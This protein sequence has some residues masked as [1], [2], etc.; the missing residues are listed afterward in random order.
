MKRSEAF[1]LFGNTIDNVSVNSN[2]SQPGLGENGFN[3][4]QELEMDSSYVD[5]HADTVQDTGSGVRPVQLHSHLFYEIL[6]CESADFQYLIGT[7]R[8]QIQNGDII[9]ITP[10]TSHRPLFPDHMPKPYH[11]LIMWISPG[12]AKNICQSSPDTTLLPGKSYVLRTAGTPYQR[13]RRLFE[14]SLQE[15]RE[16]APGWQ[17]ALCSNAAML[18]VYLSRAGQTRMAETAPVFNELLDRII[19]YVDQNYPNKITLEET[20]HIF[21][22]SSSMI[23]HLFSSQMNVSFHRYVV[24][25]RLIASKTLLAEGTPAVN[26]CTLTGFSD[27]SA[28]YRAF[29]KEYG[30]SPSQ[31]QRV[32]AASV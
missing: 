15:S 9:V 31:Y 30:I 6:Y 11:R 12:F 20:A 26:V 19:T 5:S 10:G 22:V 21:A 24:Q 28:F 1:A 16:L 2:L 29:R 7:E 27:Y 3:F 13:L 4:Y 8:S 17:T 25:R 14:S 18:F 32:V 23:T